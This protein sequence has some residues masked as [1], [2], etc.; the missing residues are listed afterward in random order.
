MA[1]EDGSGGEKGLGSDGRE[2]GRKG[3]EDL[4]G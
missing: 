1:M 3:L 4:G 2:G